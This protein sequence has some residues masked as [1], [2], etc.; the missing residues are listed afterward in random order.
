MVVVGHSMGGGVAQHYLY[1]GGKAAGL[2]LM[3]S[4]PPHGLLRASMAMYNRNPALWDE[5]SRLRFTSLRNVDLAIIERALLSHPQS[6]EKRAQLFHRMGE[7]AVAASFDLMGWRPVAPFPWAT[8]PMLV[9]GGDRD[10]FIPPVDVQLTGVYYGAR[11]IMRAGV[12]TR[13]HA[14]EHLAGGGGSSHPLA[15]DHL[16]RG[17][18][19]RASAICVRRR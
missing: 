1:Q 3:A 16:R 10:E 2:V 6:E 18:R 9:I 4:A 12:R 11:P 17:G 19:P 13:H 7:P 14:G 15:G 8:P 5:L